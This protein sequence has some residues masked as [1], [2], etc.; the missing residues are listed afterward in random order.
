[1]FAAPAHART[2]CTLI[3]EPTV[4]AL[5]ETGDCDQRTTPASTF[6]LALALI[7]FETGVLQSPELPKLPYKPDYPAWGGKNWTQA[8]TP[9]RWMRYSV[10]WYSQQITPLIGKAKLEHYAKAFGYGNADFSG[11]P[12]KANGLSRAWLTSSLQISPREQVTFLSRMLAGELPLSRDAIENTRKITASHT[13]ADKWLVFGKTGTAFPRKANGKF[14]YARGWSWYVGWAER[15]GRQVVFARLRQDQS[16]HKR[17]GG[18]RTRDGFLA[19]FDALM[20]K[21]AP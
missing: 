19:E 4:G 16:R 5:H 10:V 6:K 3:I 11:D 12:G 8:T 7:G 17:S 2:I 13:T 15:S 9:H 1:M 14:D 21:A 20:R 18:L